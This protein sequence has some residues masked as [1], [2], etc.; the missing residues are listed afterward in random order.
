V[1]IAQLQAVD[2]PLKPGDVVHLTIVRGSQTIHV[3]VKTFPDPRDAQ[4]AIIGIIPEQ[5][6]KIVHLPV[7]VRI[8]S[9]GIG[10][11]SAGLAFTL[12]L[13]RKLGA[14]VTH[15]YRVAATGEMRLDGTVLPIGGV[16]QKTWGVR[17]A[18][19]Q[20]FL[21]PAGGNARRA[22]EFAGPNLRVIPVRTL[23]QA[24]RALAALP[25]LH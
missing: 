2:A 11:P 23:K 20:V 15:G 4:R 21:V 22:R 12:E 13:M 25:K 19:A 1:T 16:Q 8:D 17:A 7:K 3:S 10:G 5:S 18:G 24:L 9:E 6:T 14:N